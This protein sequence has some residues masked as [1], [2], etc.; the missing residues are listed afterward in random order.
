MNETLKWFH[1]LKAHPLI[2]DWSVDRVPQYISQLRER[3]GCGEKDLDL[4]PRSLRKL[5]A[6]LV[7]LLQAVQEGRAPMDDD[8]KLH[9]LR[10]LT[11]YLGQVLVENLDGK[12]STVGRTLNSTGIVLYESEVLE[13]LRHRGVT[14]GVITWSC[15]FFDLVRS[16]QA[17]GSLLKEYQRLKR[18]KKIKARKERG[19]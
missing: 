2:M 5:E 8:E 11:A 6:K 9:I 17:E 16:G 18:G 14:Y 13:H 19:A 1:D 4:S 3:L 7:P 10:G 12:W 15:A